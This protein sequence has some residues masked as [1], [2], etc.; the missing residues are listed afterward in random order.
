M[1]LKQFKAKNCFGFGDSDYLVLDSKSEF[2]TILGRNSSGKTSLLNA[3]SSLKLDIK[4]GENK[5]FRN[6]SDDSDA[7][8]Q[9]I[10]SL[11]KTELVIEKMID[12]IEKKILSTNQISKEEFD[13]NPQL[14]ELLKYIMEI[15]SALFQKLSNVKSA[16]VTKLPSGNFMFSVDDN[17]DE[18]KNRLDELRQKIADTYNT[19]QGNPEQKFIKIENKNIQLNFSAE[20]IEN[21]IFKQFPNIYQFD[22]EN[23]LIN[24]FPD[25]IKLEDLT[26]D[27]YKDNTLVMNFIS[28]LGS[29][30]VHNFLKVE[31]PDKQEKLLNNLKAKIKELVKTVNKHIRNKDLLEIILSSKN[32]LQ[33]TFKT[34]GKPSY[35]YQLSENTQLLFG[36]HLFNEVYEFDDDIILIDEPNS[37]FHATVQ[38]GLRELL[39]LLAKS[40]QVIITTHSEYM[41]DTDDLTGIKIMSKDKDGRLYVR[42]DFHDQPRTKGDYLAL[43]PLMT[44]IGLEIGNSLNTKKKVILTEGITDMYYLKAFKTILGYSF[45]LNIAPARGDTTIFSL[46]P[47][48][49]SQGLKFKIVMDINS[50]AKVKSTIQE[51]WMIEDKY[52]NEIKV[53]SEY[54]KKFSDSGIE[55]LFTKE[56]YRRLVEGQHKFSDSENKAFAAMTNSAFVN[57]SSKGNNLK[58]VVAFNLFLN[59]KTIKTSNF[60]DKTIKNFKNVLE[61]C[62]KNTWKK[63]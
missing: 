34:E 23:K 29:D 17:F 1:K 9:A 57:Q 32:G 36:Y 46:I 31:D 28:Y 20:E 25:R 33:I 13:D 40:N 39:K 21:N 4:P 56:D 55:D 30:D 35:Y 8:L 60:D 27:S 42:N 61:F 47:L 15:Y 3:I 38:S 22:K 62:K 45:D 59:S 18:A 14:Q 10:F 44:A 58:R 50:Q 48:I 26:N 16:Y 49:I 54:K 53:P 41:I 43:Q 7:Y 63:V 51:S 6:F 11:K 37:G 52:I 19:T 2:Y 24:E 12:T 5:R